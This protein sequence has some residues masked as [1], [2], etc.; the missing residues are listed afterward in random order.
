MRKTRYFIFISLASMVCSSKDTRESNSADNNFVSGA[1]PVSQ[2]VEKD[3]NCPSSNENISRLS[4][5]EKEVW[6]ETIKEVPR[7][8][9][10]HNLAT[11]DECEH[12]IRL[13]VKKGL[14]V[15]VHSY[16]ELGPEVLIWGLAQAALII[17]YGTNEKIES[18]SRTNRQ[19]CLDFGQDRLGFCAECLSLN[20]QIQG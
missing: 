8:F 9:I 11:K 19:A 2:C 17:P 18:G 15:R 3:G 14:K 7:I 4:S 16:V 6:I 13:G 10:I 12:L 1:A 20:G 5:H